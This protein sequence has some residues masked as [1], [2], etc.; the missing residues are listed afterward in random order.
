[1][2]SS[3][4]LRR[5]GVGGGAGYWPPAGRLGITL[6]ELLILLAAVGVLI[7]IALPTLKP[8]PQESAIEMAKEQLL[9]LHA[10]EQAYFNRNGKY[11]PLSTLAKDPTIAKDFD[12]RVASDNPTVEDIT[13]RG[14]TSAGPIFDIV[15]T[16]PDG[17][18]YKVDQTG[19]I[20][21]LQ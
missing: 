1:M 7:F 19:R 12:K 18:R 5:A 21:P 11:A 2:R 3:T 16:R 20:V 8:S 13:F 14:P 6:L 15:A 17:S 4:G 9:Y 10:R